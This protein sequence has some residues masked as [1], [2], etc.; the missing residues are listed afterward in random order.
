MLTEF[1]AT[2]GH[3]IWRRT[4]TEPDQARPEEATAAGIDFLDH[5]RALSS[6]LVGHWEIR[7]L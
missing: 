2:K 1:I 3:R 6:A 5:N 4:P 7:N